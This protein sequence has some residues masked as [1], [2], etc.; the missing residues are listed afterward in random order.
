MP[1]RER[2]VQGHHRPFTIGRLTGLFDT[3]LEVLHER[4]HGRKRQHLHVAIAAGVSV[5]LKPEQ[6]RTHGARDM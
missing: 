1:R 6:I 2:T 4:I 3:R 5:I